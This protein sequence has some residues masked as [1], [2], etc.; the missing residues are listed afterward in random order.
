MKRSLRA[1]LLAATFCTPG[2]ALAQDASQPDDDSGI[3]D[4]R[5]RFK[6]RSMI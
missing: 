1:L 5:A 3:K 2:I 4:I 6:S